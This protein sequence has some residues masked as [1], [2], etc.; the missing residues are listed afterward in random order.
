MEG[1]VP[2]AAFR[3]RR[4]LSGLGTSAARGRTLLPDRRRAG[5]RSDVMVLTAPLDASSRRRPGRHQTPRAHQAA[6]RW[7]ICVSVDSGIA[8]E[9]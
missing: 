7:K 8:S 1:R 4:F 6:S 5:Q 3:H 9:A 2:D